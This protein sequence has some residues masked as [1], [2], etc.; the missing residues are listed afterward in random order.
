MEQS[1]GNV[2]SFQPDFI[3]YRLKISLIEQTYQKS[4]PLCIPFV[5]FSFYSELY[6]LFC[7]QPKV[8]F[9]VFSKLIRPNDF[10]SSKPWATHGSR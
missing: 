9:E 2:N 8:W 10:Q 7:F 5:S 1:G 4:R 3:L 6:Y